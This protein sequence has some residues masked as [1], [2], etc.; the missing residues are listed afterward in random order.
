MIVLDCNAAIAMALRT[1]EG[2]GLKMLIETSEE[3]TAPTLLYAELSRTMQ[4]YVKGGFLSKQ[5]AAEKGTY[6]LSLVDRFVD[7]SQF[8]PEAMTLSLELN[9]PSYDVF[10]LLLARRTG[11]TV[12]TLDRKL[13]NLCLDNGVNCLFTDTEF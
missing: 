6:A 2:Q 8:W 1:E 13:Q 10:Y 12:F 11:A 5:A 9:H 4:K 7:D 3:I